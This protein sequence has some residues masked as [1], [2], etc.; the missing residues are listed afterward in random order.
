MDWTPFRSSK[1]PLISRLKRRNQAPGEAESVYTGEGIEFSSTKPLEPGDD[2]HDLDL[3]A[4]VQSGEEE[5]IQRME[6]RQLPVYLWVDLSG[7][8]RRTEGMFFGGKARVRN[9]ALG[10][11]AFSAWNGYSPVGLGAFDTELLKFYSAR[12]GE[13][14]CLEILNWLSDAEERLP[15]RP[16]DWGHALACLRDKVPAQSLVFLISDFYD[17]AFQ[18]DFVPL[19]RSAARRFDCVPVVIRDPLEKGGALKAPVSIA[20]ENDEGKGRA[21]IDL[22]PQR[23]SSIQA[24]SARHIQYLAEGFRRLGLDYLL[25]DSISMPECYRAMLSLFYARRRTRR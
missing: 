3:L 8:M 19:L 20:V 4:L 18:D 12:F 13:D 11:I 16:A 7:S 2:L 10:L 24:A 17:H 22:T 1:I 5:I 9:N 14:Y 25:L 15:R 21:E 23:L 6:G